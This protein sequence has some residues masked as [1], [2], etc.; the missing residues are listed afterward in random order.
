MKP[1]YPFSAMSRQMSR[2]GPTPP[3]YGQRVRGLPGM[4]APTHHEFV[5]SSSRNPASTRVRVLA[6]AADTAGFLS[7]CP[8]LLGHAPVQDLY[9]L[10]LLGADLPGSVTTGA[11]TIAALQAVCRTESL[12]LA[13]TALHMHHSSVAARLARAEQVL[14]FP[15][16]TAPGRSRLLLALALRHLRDADPGR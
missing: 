10:V 1:S 8:G 13:A 16:R 15:V 14:G 6:V 12:R 7:R 9:A 4:L 5:P 11:V 2:N 3:T